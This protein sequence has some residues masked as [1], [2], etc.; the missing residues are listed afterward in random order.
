MMYFRSSGLVSSL[1][2][3]TV[4]SGGANAY[5][6][7]ETV[8]YLDGPH[9][10][11]VEM[12]NASEE[13]LPE[14]SRRDRY[15]VCR[16]TGKWEL[17]SQEVCDAFEA[18]SEGR[19]PNRTESLEDFSEQVAAELSEAAKKT[20]EALRWRYRILGPP[21]PYS[22]RESEWSFDGGQWHALPTRIYGHSEMRPN[23]T[24]HLTDK[25]KADT[26]ALLSEELAEPL[27][28]VLFREAY[29]LRNSSPRSAL[30]IGVAALEAGFKEL[31]VELKPEEEEKLRKQRTP[32]AKMLKK[33]LPKLPAKCTFEG[34]VLPLPPKLHNSMKEAIDRRNDVV[35]WGDSA[36]ERK[37]LK[38]WLLTIQDVLWL[39]DYYRGFEWALAHV[40]EETKEL[41]SHS[42]GT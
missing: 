23:V 34:K 33:D 24:V 25:G 22:H 40:R 27:G 8:F 32:L 37:V 16:V 31:V 42:A 18:L 17:P 28:H 9:E 7:S 29:M 26:E 11:L 14:L 2:I 10:I 3:R 6:D 1:A 15:L 4:N 35:H 5:E 20:A 30:V 41:L 36:A 38:E 21:S 13:D 12:R 39:L 19:V